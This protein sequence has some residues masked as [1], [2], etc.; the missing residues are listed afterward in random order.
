LKEFGKDGTTLGV[1]FIA[2][3]VVT[4]VT[5]LCWGVWVAWQAWSNIERRLRIQYAKWR[6]SFWLYVWVSMSEFRICCA[7]LRLGEISNY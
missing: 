2:T 5:L 3:S 6:V 4:A 1:F 7:K